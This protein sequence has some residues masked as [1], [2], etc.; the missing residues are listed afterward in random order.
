MRTSAAPMRA[1]AFAI[2]LIG[3]LVA[4]AILPAGCGSSTVGVT[5]TA[6]ATTISLAVSA[7]EQQVVDLANATAKAL[8]TDA[9]GTIAAINAGQ[10]PYSD[11]AHADTYAFVDN[12]DM[13]VVAHASAAVRGTNVKGQPDVT[14][15][16]WRDE[17]LQS[18]I[19][20]K[21]GW[22]DYVYK[23]ASSATGYVNKAV[24]YQP[25]TGSDGV[26]YIAFATHTVGPY[27]GTTQTAAGGP[28]EVKTFVEE[29]LAYAKQHGKDAAIKE[30][31]NTS[32]SFYRD[33]GRLYIFAYDMK[34]IVL[35]LPAEPQKVGDNRWDLQDEKGV[36]FVRDFVSVATSAGAG[37]VF[38]RYPN[39]AQNM[40]VQDKS[41]YVAKVDDGWLLGAGIYTSS[42]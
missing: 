7:V 4:L 19:A 36:Y 35:C 23:D 34:G 15:K 5:T 9:P 37:W 2:M 41:S 3:A 10:K 29:A 11:A 8:Q 26:K 31:M 39:P 16:L 17:I 28:A 38:Y 13:T 27:T 30:F 21:S 6:D 33:N 32:G 22:M 12:M 40:Q 18:A 42:E 20:G 24:Y 14:G 1:L 25:V